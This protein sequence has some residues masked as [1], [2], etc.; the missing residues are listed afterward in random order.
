MESHRRKLTY[1]SRGRF[2]GDPLGAEYMCECAKKNC[3]T[4]RVAAGPNLKCQDK[5]SENQCKPRCPPKA[6]PFTVSWID[7]ATF[8]TCICDRDE[9][10]ESM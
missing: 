8:E 4:E 5:L 3:F 7:G 9:H 1:T 2:S 6:D 10:Y